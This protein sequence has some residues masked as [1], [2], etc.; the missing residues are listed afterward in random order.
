[1]KGKEK[2]TFEMLQAAFPV[3]ETIKQSF[4]DKKIGC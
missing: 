4:G 1:M 2:N 3:R